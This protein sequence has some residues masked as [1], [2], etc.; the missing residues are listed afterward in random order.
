MAKGLYLNVMRKRNGFIWLCARTWMI[1]FVIWGKY[2]M[3]GQPFRPKRCW[4]DWSSRNTYIC[5]CDGLRTP[6]LTHTHTRRHT[7]RR[8]FWLFPIGMRICWG[9]RRVLWKTTCWQFPFYQWQHQPLILILNFWNWS[10]R[11]ARQ[12]H[13]VRHTTYWLI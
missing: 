7:L 2:S 1:L 13:F 3:H 4:P 10:G 5:G 9:R 6:S 11:M 12:C 8:L